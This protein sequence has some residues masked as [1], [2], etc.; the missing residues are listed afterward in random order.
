MTPETFAAW[1]T[2]K[3]G[4]D[5]CEDILNHGID[6]G[7]PGLLTTHDCVRLFDRYA[8]E[9]WALA[10]EIA[11]DLDESV[12]TFIGGFRRADMLDD[13]DTFR[14]LL[15]WFAAEEYA[16]RIADGYP[17]AAQGDAA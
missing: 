3:F 16:R 11:G 6:A 10:V 17:V 1:M 4:R 15:V 13:W 7:F 9:I 12:T 5:E 8:S 14:N 2:E